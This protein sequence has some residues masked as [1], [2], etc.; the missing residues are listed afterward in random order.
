MAWTRWVAYQRERFPLAAH[1]PLIAAFSFSAVS[2]SSLLRDRSDP[3]AVSSAVVAFVTSL[4]FFLQLRIA[5]EF[6]DAVEDARFRPYRPVPRGLVTLT[7]LRTVGIAAALLQGGL[8]IWLD[9][10]LLLLLAP[11]WLYLW[12]M[13]REFFV[14]RWLRARPV[15]YMATHML[16]VPLVDFYA[17]ACDWWVAGLSAPPAGLLWFLV[18]SFCNGVVIELGRKIRAPED[19]EVGVETYSALWGTT[20]AALAW[21]GT[22]VAAGVCALVSAAALASAVPLAVALVSLLGACAVTARRFADAPVRADGRKFEALSWVWTVSM[23][24][25]L[26]ILPLVLPAGSR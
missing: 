4:A 20:G 21:L 19:E 22:L 6:K 14:P 8:A 25:T 26:G 7:E 24:L 13:T 1:A 2:F 3:P 12:L 11:T 16:I 10:S 23:Y 17:T 9:P 15:A 18:V 5:D